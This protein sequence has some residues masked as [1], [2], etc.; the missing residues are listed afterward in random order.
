MKKSLLLIF[1]ALASF[2]INAQTA[3]NFNCNDCNNV[4]HD[5]FAE[6]NAG[7][8]IVICW[9]MPCSACIAP[10][11]N[12]AT[13]AQS[14]AS[15]NPGQVKFY[16]CDDSGNTT[17]TTLDSWANTNGITADANFSSSTIRMNDYGAAGMPKIVVLGGGASH[18][19]FYNAN[20]TF[21][22]H[23]LQGSVD[24]ALAATGITTINNKFSAVNLFPNPACGGSAVLNYSL[25]EN[26]DVTIHVY[27]T[28]GEKMNAVTF[29]NEATGK[30]EATLDLSA[31][32]KGVYFI[33][34]IAGES[35][36]VIK[37]I[38]TE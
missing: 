9:V 27:N 1:T 29:E 21:D 22:Y 38:V 13:M 14:Y 11:L 16:L 6:L 3:T 23:Q 8:V 7:K 28:I 30:H 17:C 24:N 31:F 37:F 32:S 10:S 25:A 19:V 34:L 15:S 26:A 4:N 33:R 20:N 2:A 5:L 35:S 12:C 18:T 36:Q